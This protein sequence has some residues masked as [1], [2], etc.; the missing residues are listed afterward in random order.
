MLEDIDISYDVVQFNGTFVHE[1]IYR[2]DAGPEVD[3]AWEALGVGCEWPTFLLTRHLPCC[4][5]LCMLINFHTVRPSIVPD[6][7]AAKSGLTKDHAHRKL[8]YGGGYPV[9]VEG[10]HQLHCL[11]RQYTLT[12]YTFTS[13]S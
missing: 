3:A 11:V 12:G 8:Q 4:I 1:N 5:D 10:L 9:F 6:S 2:Q 7:L 13:Q